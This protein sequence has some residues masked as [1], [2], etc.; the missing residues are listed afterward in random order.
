MQRPTH[1]HDVLKG[2]VIVA[3]ALGAEA[4]GGV[5]MKGWHES[6]RPPSELVCDTHGGENG[7]AIRT[8]A[9]RTTYG[10]MGTRSRSYWCR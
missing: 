10:Q 8:R 3:H 5:G 2:A 1:L 9:A 6:G 7:R 4:G